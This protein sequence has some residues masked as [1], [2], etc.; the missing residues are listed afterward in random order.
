MSKRTTYSKIY[1]SDVRFVRMSARVRD[2]P[3]DGF[4]PVR[5][6]DK[7]ASARA[8]VPAGLGPHGRG[9]EVILGEGQG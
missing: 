1:H 5:T 7:N 6:D 3:T 2:Y 4:L 9:A 8:R